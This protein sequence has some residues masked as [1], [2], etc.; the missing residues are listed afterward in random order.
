MS[1]V[2]RHA[3]SRRGKLV[4]APQVSA[5]AAKNGFGKILDRVAREGRLAITKHDEPCAVLISIEEYRALV[6]AKEV[7]LNS[8]SDEFDALFERMQAPDAAAAMQKAFTLTP[9]QLGRAAVKSAAPAA[10]GRA[11]NKGARRA[12]G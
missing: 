7:T 1:A 2:V 8:L 12:R 9:A 10:A 5:S 11:R 6:G 3:R 4:D